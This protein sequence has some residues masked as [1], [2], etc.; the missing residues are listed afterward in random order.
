MMNQPVTV[1]LGGGALDFATLAAIGSAN[2][3]VQVD[4]AGLE[5]AERGRLTFEA[6]LAAGAP[7]YGATTGVGAMK[8]I[9]LNCEAL[10]AFNAGLV[11]AHHFGIGK[12][13][14]ADVVRIAIAIRINTALNGHAGCTRQLVE[15][16][17]SLLHADVVPMVRRKGS[18]GCADIGLMG[19]IGA[20][21]TGT[22]EAFYQGRLLPA[23]AALAV[24]GLAPITMVPKDSLASISVNAV[25]YAASA[26]A[27]RRAAATLRMLLGTSLTAA[28]A[29]GASSNPWEA[30]I[31]LGTKREAQIGRFLFHASRES[32]ITP[33]N[34]V[35]DP[36]SLRMMAQV[37][38][39][40]FEALSHA[41]TTVLAATGRTDDNP[42]V[43]EG[44][45]IASG[46]SLPLGVAI[47]MQSA[48]LAL[49]HAARNAF[50]RCV[51]LG[52]GGRR[53]LPVNLVPPGAIATGF[54]PVVKLA[55]DLFMQVLSMAA[56]VSAQSMA[57]AGGM[58]DEATFLPLAI[59]RFEHQ[60]EA[61]SSLAALEAL[62]AAQAIDLCGDRP[63]GLAA[64]VHAIVRNQASFYDADR[65]LSDEIE[66]TKVDLTAHETLQRLLEIAPLED[67]DQLFALDIA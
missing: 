57:V 21:L 58:E 33:A 7:I 17:V 14:P 20:V 24:A 47:A 42:V 50:N 37:F 26:Y 1:V 46:G 62:L 10:A 55:G 34:E 43:I 56:P 36:L 48:S 41:G 15:F 5:R 25:A 64:M 6:A 54:G 66:A 18:I 16:Y 3:M 9:R 63:T 29:L 67:F 60:V 11:R 51:L 13:F 4:P 19:Q 38:A 22:G 52:N 49:A 44:R 39:P 35:H 30:A 28:V 40:V 12:P 61:L 31:H 53:G 23:E 59:E 65:P 27:L 32:G 2:A 45:V 8:D